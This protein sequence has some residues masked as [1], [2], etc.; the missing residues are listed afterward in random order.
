MLTINDIKNGLV[1]KISST[2]N[3]DLLIALDKL[4]ASDSADNE[5]VKLTNERK[6]ILKK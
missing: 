4:I 3:K 1:D 5:I 2:D 6:E